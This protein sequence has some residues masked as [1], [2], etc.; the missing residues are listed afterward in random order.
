MLGM[1]WTSVARPDHA[2]H[3]DPLNNPC[4][5]TTALS[6][7]TWVCLQSAAPHPDAPRA[8]QAHGRDSDV[9]VYAHAQ[10]C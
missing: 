8:T 4:D 9:Y 10:A 3:P 2:Q 1:G 7:P 6:L 5:R